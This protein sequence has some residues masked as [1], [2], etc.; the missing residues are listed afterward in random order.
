M[1][2]IF[3]EK[4]RDMRE[5]LTKGSVSP[6]LWISLRSPTACEI[7][8]GA[9]LDRVVVDAE[10]SP[11]NIETLYHM[12]MAFFHLESPL[13]LFSIWTDITARHSCCYGDKGKPQPEK[14]AAVKRSEEITGARERA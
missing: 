3:V 13:V 7:I 14:A 12:L 8:A 2:M 11:F 1:Q 9:G 6:G 4:A 5:K 10:H